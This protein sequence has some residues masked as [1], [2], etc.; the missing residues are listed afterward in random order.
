MGKIKINIIFKSIIFYEPCS[1][2]KNDKQFGIKQLNK[3]WGT[4]NWNNLALKLQNQYLLI[5]SSHSETNIIEG[6]Y[7]PENLNFREACAVLNKCNLY[8]GLE[9]GF[10]QAAAALN[11]KAVV[12]FGGW[13]DPKIIGYDFFTKTFITITKNPPVENT[14]AYVIIAKKPES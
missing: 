9:G 8:V 13:I 11:K 10:V 5:Q 6:V 12:Y 4:N 3:D 2:K 1:T 14:K 7:K